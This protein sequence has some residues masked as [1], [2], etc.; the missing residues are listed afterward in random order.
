MSC[1]IVIT[2]VCL[3]LVGKGIDKGPEAFPAPVAFLIVLFSCSACLSSCPWYV[4][5]WISSVFSLFVIESSNFRQTFD[6]STSTIS[7]SAIALA[8][9]VESRTPRKVELS[10][11]AVGKKQTE[12]IVRFINVPV[13]RLIIEGGLTG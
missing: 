3:W 1:G 13:S 10:H 4:V 11:V 5:I 8:I 12:K 7:L 9:L 2:L 6:E